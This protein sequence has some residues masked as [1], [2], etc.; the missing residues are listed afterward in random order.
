M[1]ANFSEYRLGFVDLKTI[2][3]RK[4]KPRGES[5]DAPIGRPHPGVYLQVGG[6]IVVISS[7]AAPQ[8]RGHTRIRRTCR[9]SRRSP[10]LE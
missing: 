7:P 5:V 8:R 1:G 2:G 9:T 6:L 4:Q 10:N 3:E